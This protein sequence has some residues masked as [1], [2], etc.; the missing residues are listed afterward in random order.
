[1]AVKITLKTKAILNAVAKA[2]LWTTK[3]SPI[4]SLQCIRFTYADN[5]LEL[6]AMDGASTDISLYL[7]VEG[8]GT[9]DVCIPVDRILPK[10]QVLAKT[11]KEVSMSFGKVIMLSTEKHTSRISPIGVELFPTVDRDFDFDSGTEVATSEFVGAIKKTMA[12]ADPNSPYPALEGIFFNGNDM[13]SADGTKIS[14]YSKT[15]FVN[16]E[17]LVPATSLA[18]IAKAIDGIAEVSVLR[19]DKKFVVFWNGGV[20][21]STM[22]DYAFPDYKS[23]I[24]KDFETTFTMHKSDLQEAKGLATVDA[25]E[26]KNL[27]IIDAGDGAILIAAE[28]DAGGHSSVITPKEY[29]GPSKRFGISIKY[30]KDAIMKIQSPLITFGVND[31]SGL[32]ML[33]GGEFYKYGI[34]PMYVK[35]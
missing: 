1:M 35:E 7:D 23:L 3:N 15:E 24:P 28:S 17:T 21:A 4:Q 6:S 5:I 34:M 8:E 26:S 33:Y 25:L 16:T 11:S 32:I 10:L 18:R 13:V 31:P 19:S 12:S 29:S 2:S 22:I 27:I 20:I 30:V 9:F 14:I